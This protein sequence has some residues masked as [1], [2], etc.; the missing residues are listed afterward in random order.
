MKGQTG[1]GN[2]GPKITVTSPAPYPSFLP[3]ANVTINASAVDPD[4]GDT[5]VQMKL[6]ELYA[7]WSAETFI[8]P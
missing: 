7:D 4:D 8:G 2:R 3:G 5:V 1:M 6:Y